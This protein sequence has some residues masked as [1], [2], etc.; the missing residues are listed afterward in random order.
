ME[1]ESLTKL[2]R[3]S[4]DSSFD[5]Q[6]PQAGPEVEQSTFQDDN[7][8]CFEFLDCSSTVDNCSNQI[9]DG[10]GARIGPEELIFQQSCQKAFLLDSFKARYAQ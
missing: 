1:L 9:N 8:A 10:W 3:N 6:Q 4:S 5:K 2:M 7:E